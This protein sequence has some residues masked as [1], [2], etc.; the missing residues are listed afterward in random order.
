M[1]QV[2]GAKPALTAGASS[3]EHPAASTAACSSSGLSESS[4]GADI[5]TRE[6]C[7]QQISEKRGSSD[8]VA[9]GFLDPAGLGAKRETIHEEWAV[10]EG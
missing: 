8:V 7:F 5:A 4:F 10:N 9:G 6:H 1:L 3:S 2:S